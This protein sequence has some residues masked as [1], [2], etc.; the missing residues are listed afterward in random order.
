VSAQNTLV[1][2]ENIKSRGSDFKLD[3]T[4]TTFASTNTYGFDSPEKSLSQDFIFSGRLSTPGGYII[5]SSLWFNKDF[6]NE[7]E[8][9]VRDSLVSI[10]K[11]YGEIV[12]GI[13]LTNRASLTLAL[14]EFSDKTAGLITAARYNP[15]LSHQATYLLDGLTIIYRPTFIWNFHEFNN[16]TDGASN[17]QQTI[18]QRVTLFYMATESLFLSLD[19]TYIKSWSYDGNTN[20]I[21]SLDQSVTYAPN[22]D[23]SFFLGHSIGGNSLAVN[24]QETKIEIFDTR[25]SQY[26][27]G[28][29]YQF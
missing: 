6:K 7:R 24:G 25:Q 18:N 27:I 15:I 9:N 14:S 20:D 22:R 16:R 8:L 17:Y 3:G 28:L 11:P 23:L 29:S 19:N 12:K 21:Y 5:S 4:F 10:T 2:L 13:S 26:Y 1:E